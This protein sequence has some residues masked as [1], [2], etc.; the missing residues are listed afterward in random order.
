[1]FGR[2]AEGWT[3]DKIRIGFYM[4]IMMNK[5]MLILMFNMRSPTVYSFRTFIIT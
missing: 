2:P 3:T 1:M 4:F 5:I